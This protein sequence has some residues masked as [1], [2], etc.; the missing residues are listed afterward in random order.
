LTSVRRCPLVLCGSARHS[1]A[2]RPQDRA[3]ANSFARGDA[4]HQPVDR[5]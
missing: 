2:S 4:N 1:G 3:C 5:V